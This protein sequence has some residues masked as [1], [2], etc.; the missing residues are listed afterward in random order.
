MRSFALFTAVS[1]LTLGF[2]YGLIEVVSSPDLPDTAQ[3][4]EADGHLGMEAVGYLG[5]VPF[6]PR[7]VP[8]PLGLDARIAET[9][10]P[11]LAAS[12]TTV[13]PGA[14]PRE[15][16]VEDAIFDRL[17]DCESGKWNAQGQPIHDSAD[18]DS[19]G[20]FDG[21]LQF[22]ERTWLEFREPEMAWSA[23]YASR[24]DQ[25]RVAKRVL[26]AQ[27]WDAWPNCSRKVGVWSAG[28]GS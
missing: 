25:I 24:E 14:T 1:M 22:E 21:G 12:P 10:A 18:W 27:G 9:P 26:A 19:S 13:S 4:H 16:H 28:D 5:E 23:A 20:Y 8:I 6:V 11:V 17:A 7:D 3:S 15:V 2:R